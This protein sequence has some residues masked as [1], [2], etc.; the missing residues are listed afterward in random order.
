M[1]R[2]RNQ[3]KVFDSPTSVKFPREHAEKLQIEAELRGL[4]IS[5]AI[6]E[7]VDHWME[8]KDNHDVKHQ[9]SNR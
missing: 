3:E 9:M 7:A 2:G 8:K 6:R 5:G 1:P 4:T